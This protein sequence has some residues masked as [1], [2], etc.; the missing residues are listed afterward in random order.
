MSTARK[1]WTK[2]RRLKW[3]VGIVSTAFSC[4]FPCSVAFA[5][6]S[7][8]PLPLSTPL[9]PLGAAGAINF[10]LQN[11]PAPPA[12][13]IALSSLPVATLTGGLDQLAGGVGADLGTIADQA[14]APLLNTLMQRLGSGGGVVALPEAPGGSS[15]FPPTVTPWASALGGHSNISGDAVSRAE[16][17]STGVAGFAAGLETRIGDEAIL[18][19]S[20]AVAHESTRAGTGGVSKSN[21]VTLALYGRQGLFGQGYAAGAIAYGWHDTTTSRT[22]TVSGTDILEGKFTGHDLSGRIEAGWR[23]A[24]PDRAVLAPFLAFGGDTYSTPNYGETAVAGAPTFALTYD[25]NTITNQHIEAGLHLART[26]NLASDSVSFGL[27]A[28]WAHQMSGSPVIDVAF[29]ELSGSNFQVR[30]LAPAKDSALVGA[31]VQLQGGGGFS[32]GVRGDGQFGKGL[33]ALSGTLSLV[34]DF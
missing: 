1:T 20:A 23:F 13:F 16:H 4:T 24:M 18:G 3:A 27:D 22:L 19:A 2:Q 8:P 21:D 11:S 34:Y 17:V 31:G 29:A 33:S 30:G 26:F 14:N 15:T 28:A 25:S 6:P 12:G 5:L 9:N 32:Y 7:L 10:A